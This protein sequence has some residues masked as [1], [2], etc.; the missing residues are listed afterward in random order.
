MSE[1]QP[2][3]FG[4]P[5]FTTIA[6]CVPWSGRPLPPELVVAYKAC[7]PPMATN[8][9]F[10]ETRGAPIADARNLFAEK[11]MELKAKYI[12]FWDEDVLLPPQALRELIFLMENWPDIGVA[13]GIYC[14]KVDRPEPLVFHKE[15]QGP[16]WDWKVGE[17]FE[18]SGIGMGCTVIRTEILKDV[19]KPWFRTVDDYSK[20]LDN[21]PSGEGWT[22]DLWFCHRVKKTKWKIVAHGQ[23]L[24]PHID[25]RTGRRYELPPDSKPC[26]EMLMPPNKK[27]ILD[28]GAGAQPFKTNEGKVVTVDIRED[29]G[30]DYRCDFRRLPF[31]TESF[32]VVRSSHSLEHIPRVQ[33][34]DTLDEW[35]RVL[36][37]EGELR[38]I[39]PN[40]E[41]AA[42]QIMAGDFSNMKGSNVNALDVLYGQQKYS[43]DF[44]K[45]GFTPKYLRQLLDKRGF[46]KIDIDTPGFNIVCNAWKNGKKVPKVSN[47]TK[48]GRA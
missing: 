40:I 2:Q 7:S 5:N 13:G 34:E 11:A 43:E 35:I 26:R 48:K 28:L 42:K 27:R 31:A 20:F 19:E 24:C 8:G 17:V 4:Y 44:H 41:W 46:K 10:L 14:L 22:E 25:V 16:Y 21:I 15:G 9:V 1:P 23:L 39:I 32:D 6:M 3:T 47:G 45:G 18:V 33:Q 37:H 30:A 36:K 29:V 38:L 12:F